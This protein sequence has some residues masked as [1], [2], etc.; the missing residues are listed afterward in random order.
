MLQGA[1]VAVSLRETEIDA[2]DEVS[3]STTSV[4]DKVGWLD[5]AMDQVSR[6]HELHALEHLIGD[7]ED[8]LER[9]STA[10]LVKLI[11][12]RGSKEVHDHEVVRILGSKVVDLGKAWGVLQFA[13]D[14]VLVTQLRASCS[15]LLK[16]YGYL[17]AIGTHSKV[18]VSEGPSADALGDSVFLRG[19]KKSANETKWACDRKKRFWL[20][21]KSKLS[22]RIET[23]NDSRHGLEMDNGSSSTQ[24]LLHGILFAWVP[25]NKRHQPRYP[26]AE[27]KAANSFNSA[28]LLG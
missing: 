3:I 12:E 21:N 24:H 14:F 22:N 25:M 20:V 5:I 16:L 11:F 1:G 27:C 15:V 17:F 6:V 10:A 28:N 2:V 23:E 8:G 7:H 19:K 13:V 18:N 9:E 4:S 26:S